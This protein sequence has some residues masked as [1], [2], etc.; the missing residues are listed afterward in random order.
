MQQKTSFGFSF[1]CSLYALTKHTDTV[2]QLLRMHFYFH[3]KADGW[4]LLWRWK[5]LRRSRYHSSCKCSQLKSTNWVEGRI[6][7]I[8][9]SKQFQLLSRG[10]K[11]VKS[12]FFTH[13][14]SIFEWNTILKWLT[15]FNN[16]IDFEVKSEIFH[17]EASSKAIRKSMNFTSAW[18]WA[19]R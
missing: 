14:L 2:M 15:Q 9:H 3:R 13:W 5:I 19:D 1:L 18:W 6:K 11:V 17:F 10:R 7:T 8:K 12:T 16:L 4:Q